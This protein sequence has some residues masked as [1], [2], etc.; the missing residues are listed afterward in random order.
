[1]SD[2]KEELLLEAANLVSGQRGNDYG[3]ATVNHMRIAEFWNAWI[4]N[5]AWQGPITPYD[6]SMM[7]GLVKFARCQQKPTHDSH[8]DIAGY[9]AVSENIYEY[10][11]GVGVGEGQTNGGEN[12]SPTEAE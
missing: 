12:A 2:I 11:V 8:V 3:S 9:A 7:M 5:R 1:M 10:L 6:V 4:M